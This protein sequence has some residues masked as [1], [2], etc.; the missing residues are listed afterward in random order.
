MK[1]IAMIVKNLELHG[2][3]TV[4]M[5][6]SKNLDASKFE[7]TIFSGENIN[8]EYLQECQKLNIKIIELPSKRKRPIRYYLKLFWKMKKNTYD[9]CHVH[10]NSSAMAIELL[11]AKLRKINI[12]IAHC[13]TSKSGN[14]KVHK[15]LRPFLNKLYTVACACSEE[16]GKWI[17]EDFCVLSNGIDIDK[18]NFNND[19]RE[20][21]R[22]QLD[23]H[24]N[25]IV[26]GNVG[27]FNENKNQTFLIDL[28]GNILKSNNNIKLLLVGDGPKYN[29][30]KKYIDSKDYKKNIILYGETNN[31][32]EVYSAMDIFV[33][34]SKVE[35]LGIVAIEAQANGLPCV[36]SENI[37]NDIMLTS[38]IT[39]LPLDQEIWIE[40]ILNMC[41][42]NI[43][44]QAINI[45]KMEQFSI[46]N[47]VKMLE[48]IY[49]N[50]KK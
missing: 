34:P 3:S 6:Y 29:E 16:A 28:M 50:E 1:K 40:K 27:R 25:E 47:N 12:R 2:I 7:I 18:Y 23:I 43:E 31:V 21:I 5:N 14:L 8:V 24:E 13:H 35:G 10:G 22:K 26:L 49:T 36:V 46:K 41:M 44:R 17:F 37:P 39:K 11:I 19:W 42:E 20:K 30:L 33:F 9:V 38:N 15:L 48:S 32:K 4:V 45:K